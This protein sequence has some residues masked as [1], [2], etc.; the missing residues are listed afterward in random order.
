MLTC[1]MFWLR[2]FSTK[3]KIA[4]KVA[5]PLWQDLS[6]K[7]YRWRRRG[8]M[9]NLI[10]LVVIFWNHQSKCDHEKLIILLLLRDLYWENAEGSDIFLFVFYSDLKSSFFSGLRVYL[11]TFRFF[12]SFYIIILV[13]TFSSKLLESWWGKIYLCKALWGKAYIS[14]HLHDWHRC[15]RDCCDWGQVLPNLKDQGNR[16]RLI[17]RYCLGWKGRTEVESLKVFHST[18]PL[19]LSYFIIT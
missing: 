7:K 2:I 18:E 1:T 13:S 8:K 15:L 12:L 16:L 17:F 11:K 14:Q 3:R 9:T 6:A 10:S 19:H 5:T 4:V